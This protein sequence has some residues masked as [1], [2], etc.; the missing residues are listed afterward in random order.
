MKVGIISDIHSNYEAL[1]SVLTHLTKRGVEKI[2]CAGDLVGYNNKPNEVVSEAMKR[3]ILSVKGNHDRA[4]AENDNFMG[5]SVAQKGLKHNNKVITSDN[6]SFL[7]DLPQQRR[8]DVDGTDIY[9]VHG[10]PMNPLT[11]YVYEE[12]V[13][14]YFLEKNFVKAY[15]DVLIMGHTHKPFIEK[16]DG[17]TILNPGSVGQPRDG[18]PK[19]SFAILD[20]EDVNV[21]FR[22]VSYN[23]D[24]VA[25]DVSK[26]HPGLGDR[27]K[28]GL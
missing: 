11:E 18:N 10:S 21:S 4:V 13:D 24:K 9:L 5:N 20:T 28:R 2:L 14:T 23:V 8:L 26:I 17:I 3:N 25:E 12:D 1:Q 22:R 15:P 6:R 7:Q 19:S 16:V 27:L